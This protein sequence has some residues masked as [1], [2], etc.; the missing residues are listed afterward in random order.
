MQ[1]CQNWDKG[2][3]RANGKRSS[4]SGTC[5]DW[6]KRGEHEEHEHR[7]EEE[8]KR[9]NEEEDER[10]RVAPDMGAGGSHPQA[11]SDLEEGERGTR[12]V[13]WAY[14][15]D[16]EG[17][18]DKYQ[19]TEAERRGGRREQ[20]KTTRNHQ[21][22]KKREEKS[23]TRGKKRSRE[24]QRRAQEAREETSAQEQRQRGERVSRTGSR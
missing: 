21:V 7:H 22:K 4:T 13:R 15:E 23:S 12:R 3:V 17:K 14:S 16:E 1:E 11:T 19:E 6:R 24:K 9:E 5:D 18:A 20:E 8:E 2:Q 10:V